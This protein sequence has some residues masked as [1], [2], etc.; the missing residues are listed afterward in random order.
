MSGFQ[1]RVVVVGPGEVRRYDAAEWRDAIVTVNGG[2]IDV[3]P[4]RGAPVR[5]VSGDVVA[6]DGLALRALANGGADPA[7]LVAVRRSTAP[8]SSARTG[9]S[10][11][12]PGR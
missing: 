10:S 4:E 6:L 1:R 3:E 5:F 2:A 12:P 7:V 11:R 9:G 8:G